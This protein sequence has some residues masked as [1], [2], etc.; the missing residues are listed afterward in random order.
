M[1]T[2]KRHRFRND[3][4]RSISMGA[5]RTVVFDVFKIAG[6]G[7]PILV[8]GA[9]TLD[10]AVARVMGLRASFPGE[11]LIVSKATGRRILF[12]RDGAVRRS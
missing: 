11:Y 10:A 1:P 7:E 6:N 4:A 5:S 3:T 9:P 8:E 2:T 12:T